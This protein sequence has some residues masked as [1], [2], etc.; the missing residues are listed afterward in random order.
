MSNWTPSPFS[1]QRQ[2]NTLDYSAGSATDVVAGFF[3]AVYAWMCAGLGL[4][5]VV[6]WWVST[7]PQLMRQI[8]TG[9]TLIFLF[10]VEIALVVI[11]GRALHAISGAVATGL[12]LLYAGVNGLTLSAIFVVYALPMVGAA[13]VACAAM[14][15]AMSVY[16]MVT[17]RDLTRIGSMLI[18]GLVGIIVASL[19]NIFL[20]HSQLLDYVISYAGVV[21][22]VGLTAYD[23]QRLRSIAV[24][25]G[26]NA[27][28]ASRYSIV[29]ALRLYLDFINLFLFILR[30]LGRRR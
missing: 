28:L 15:G 29:G 10:I 24:A 2:I 17:R 6:A 9:P 19:L 4:T 30:I 7:Q 27:A 13:F 16:G 20:A 21:I 14:F 22:F 1:G 12:F 5:A 25:T 8:F 23:T 18:M 11:I 26:G 3:N